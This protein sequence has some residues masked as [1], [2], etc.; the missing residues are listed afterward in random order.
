MGLIVNKNIDGGKTRSQEKFLDST[1]YRRVGKKEDLMSIPK[2]TITCNG[3]G[4][5]KVSWGSHNRKIEKGNNTSKHWVPLSNKKLDKPKKPNTLAQ[6]RKAE[7]FKAPSTFEFGKA[8]FSRWHPIKTKPIWAPVDARSVK[9]QLNLLP[10]P[11]RQFKGVR[12][13]LNKGETTSFHV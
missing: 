4:Q 1:T 3:D 6:V 2:L 12:K 11:T 9:S 5:R 8:S 10:R 7:A 13:T